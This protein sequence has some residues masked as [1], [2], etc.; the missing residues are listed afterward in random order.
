RSLAT[1][2]PADDQRRFVD[3]VQSFLDGSERA[4]AG[5]IRVRHRDGTDRWH[6]A[7]GVAMRDPASGRA[8]RFT[9]SSVDI[10][11]L[12]VAEQLLRESE[13]QFRATFDNAAVGMAVSVAGGIF[14]ACNQ[15]VCDILGY[16]KDEIVG[17][18]FDEFGV[19]DDRQEDLERHRAFVRGDV[20]SFSRDK[21]YIRK[22][23]SR[24][25]ANVSVSVLRRDATGKPTHVLAIVQD[26]SIRKSLETDLQTT[27]DRLELGIRGSGVS[28]FDVEMPDGTRETAK[29]T[30]INLWESL[31]YSESEI[32]RDLETVTGLGLVPEEVEPVSR[33]VNAYLAGT[34]PRYAVEHRL[35]HRDG[36]T[37][38][39]LARGTGLRD[40]LGVARRFIGSHID[41]TERKVVEEKLRQANERLE[42]AIRS[43]NLS[44]WEYDMPDGVL[45][46]ATQKLTNVWESLGYDPTDVQPEMLA[47]IHPEDRARVGEAIHAYL[48][49]QTTTFEV[50]H[51]VRRKDGTY[52]WVL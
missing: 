17:H 3:D 23:G 50:E 51:R 5:E 24:L 1:L 35:R 11:H 22:D 4:W 12:K 15:K 52:R 49:G 14:V 40:E 27:K 31:G 32:P 39:G 26:I 10:T 37:R 44:I 6:L 43:S 42:A 48:T 34:I 18:R 29:V 45:A 46:H 19:P 21:Q 7:R 9:G 47:V 25:W 38:G 2:I 41:I 28:I 33:A 20:A 8:T 36:S 30:A 13:E 16:T